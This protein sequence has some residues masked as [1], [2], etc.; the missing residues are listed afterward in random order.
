MRACATSGLQRSEDKLQ[1]SVLFFQNKGSRDFYRNQVQ[2]LLNPASQS[3]S[4]V[5]GAGFQC[6]A[7]DG[8]GTFS[9]DKKGRL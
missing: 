7:H 4:G 8:A 2:T 3:F 6:V 1:D 5:Q 9:S